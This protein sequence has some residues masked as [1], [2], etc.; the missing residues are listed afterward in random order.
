LVTYSN[1]AKVE[2]LGVKGT[3]LEQ[4]GAVSKEVALEMAGGLKRISGSRLCISVTG[5]A[6]PDGGTTEKPVGLVY[7]CAI[8]DGKIVEKEVRMR[9][10]G[11]KWNRNFSVLSMLNIIYKILL[12]E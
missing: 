5:I 12:D 8:F 9:N 6:G 4:F 1:K 3:T 10:V 2:E 11:R 7:I